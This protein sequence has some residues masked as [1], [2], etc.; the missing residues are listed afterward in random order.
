MNKST[1]D[2]AHTDR[3]WFVE[4]KPR[5]QQRVFLGDFTSDTPKGFE[6]T[7]APNVV[8][9]DA[10]VSQV[11]IVEDKGKK[12]YYLHIENF[13]DRTVQVHVMQL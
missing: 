9:D 2:D 7:I 4:V 12:K 13:D 10:V 6:I 5:S 8:P 11:I 3:T 1:Q